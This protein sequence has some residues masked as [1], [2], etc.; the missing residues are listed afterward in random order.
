MNVVLH[1]SF[2]LL[3]LLG[4][5]SYFIYPVLLRLLPSR[6]VS[7]VGEADLP[8]P[9]MSV[10]VTAR[11]EQARIREKI[12]NLLSLSAYPG[13][14]EIII[15][16]D[17]SDDDTD[18]IV[19]EFAEQGVVLVRSPVND[20]KEAAQALAIAAAKGELLVFSDVATSMQGDV[21]ARIAKHFADPN[22]GALSSTD[23]FLDR[24]GRPA[25]E[26]A[27]VRYEMWLRGQ[28]SRVSS[29][30][31]LSGSFFAARAEICRKNW[32]TTIPSDFMTAINCIREGSVAISADDV[33]GYYTDLADPRKEYRRKVRTVV[34]GMRA[35][36]ETRE[37]LSFS[38]YGLFAFQIWSHKIMRWVAPWC[39]L[40]VLLINLALLDTHPIYKLTL[41]VQVFF[42]GLATLGALVPKSRDL[43]AVRIPYYFVAAN[44]AVMHAALDFFRGKAVVTWTPSER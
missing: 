8:I 44:L 11:N 30:I 3:S 37:M 15:A 20:G 39:L 33:F 26:G 24:D 13:E 14:I 29:L 19:T 28:E 9:S 6:D 31:G 2:W 21:L 27:Y 10:I 18:R 22:V 34:R 25:G 40:L 1:L 38:K 41:G 32:A 4:I 7:P 12:Q 35:L 43:F 5:Y 23:R 17:A 36:A 16:S 42:Y